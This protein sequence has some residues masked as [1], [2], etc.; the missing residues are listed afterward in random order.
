VRR[1]GITDV[2]FYVVIVAIIATLV[3]PGSKAGTAVVDMIDAFAAVVGGAT[4]SAWRKQ[5]SSG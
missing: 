2:L 4:G 5:G 3:R 1:V